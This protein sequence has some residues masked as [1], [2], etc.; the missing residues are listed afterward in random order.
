MLRVKDSQVCIEARYVQAKL[1]I[2]AILNV[3]AL[4]LARKRII[5]YLIG[6]VA[7]YFMGHV[8]GTH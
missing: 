6:N 8:K 4:G 5:K 1:M 3:W 7:R 2:D